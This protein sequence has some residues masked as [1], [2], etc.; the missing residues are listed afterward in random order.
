MFESKT[1]QSPDPNSLL[2]SRPKVMIPYWTSLLSWKHPHLAVP[3]HD[4]LWPLSIHIGWYLI[5][6]IVAHSVL[7]AKFCFFIMS[8]HSTSNLACPKLKFSIILTAP[9]LLYI[10]YFSLSAPP[11]TLLP[12]QK[13]SE[14]FLFSP[15]LAS[16]SSDHV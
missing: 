7:V 6:T 3:L 1:P 5:L 14:L 2:S 15:H 8:G 13:N 11:S 9:N 16:I 12:R 10:L 4:C